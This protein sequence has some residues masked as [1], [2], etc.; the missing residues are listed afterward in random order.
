[1]PHYYINFYIFISYNYR[2]LNHFNTTSDEYS[3][4]FTN[5]ATGALKLVSESFD[6]NNGCLTYL[7]ENHTS[8]LGMRNNAPN[9]RVLEHNEA[10]NLLNNDS[11]ELISDNTKN[12]LFVY[13]AQ[14]N[15]SGTKYPLEW[16]DKVQR[17]GLNTIHNSL[18]WYCFLDAA[19]Y[20]ATNYLDLTKYKPDFVCVSFYKIFGYPTGLGALLVKATSSDVLIKKYYGGGTVFMALSTDNVAVP[21]AILHERCN[22]HYY[23]V[24]HNLT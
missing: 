6:Y 10:F 15:F 2:I 22:P 24:F 5:G 14:C 9:T 3:V 23:G 18:R 8:V 13:P 1:M 11:T 21:R 19:G 20:V 17:G 12:S 7:Q 16:I 4:I